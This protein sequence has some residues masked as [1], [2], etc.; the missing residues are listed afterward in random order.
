VLTSD[1][2]PELPPGVENRR[3]STVDEVDVERG[4]RRVA[5]Y[6]VHRCAPEPTESLERASL[7]LPRSRR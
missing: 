7:S 5:R 3:C 6:F 2:H 1:I 4:G